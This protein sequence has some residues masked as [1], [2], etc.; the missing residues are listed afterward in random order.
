MI[1]DALLGGM[2]GICNEIDR[3]LVLD[4]EAS[5]GVVT[6]QRAGS[7]G[8]IYRNG[9]QSVVIERRSRWNGHGGHHTTGL[10]DDGEL[11]DHPSGLLSVSRRD[12]GGLPIDRLC[13][14]NRAASIDMLHQ[15]DYKTSNCIGGLSLEALA[16]TIV[17][18]AQRISTDKNRLCQI[19]ILPRCPTDDIAAAS[20]LANTFYA[21]HHTASIRRSRVRTSD[22]FILQQTSCASAWYQCGL[23]RES[24]VLNEERTREEICGPGVLAKMPDFD[25]GRKVSPVQP[26]IHEGR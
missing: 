17:G 24:C 25:L 19:E 15:Q 23:R 9:E 21:S 2:V 1:D 18:L 10:F 16:D 14:A 7:L 13:L 3:I 4:A 20:N 5:A 26:E 6:Q 12:E 11:R 8:G 22:H